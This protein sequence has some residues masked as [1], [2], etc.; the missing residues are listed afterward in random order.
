MTI[1]YP[2]FQR[3]RRWGNLCATWMGHSCVYFEYWMTGLRMLCD[4]VFEDTCV[5]RGV[6]EHRLTPPPCKIE[7]I[8]FIDVVLISNSHPEHLSYRTIKKIHQ[9]HPFCQ[10]IVPKGCGDWF[11]ENGISKVTELDWCEKASF[12]ALPYASETDITSNWGKDNFTRRTIK[13]SIRCLPCQYSRPTGPGSRVKGL[14][15]SWLIE[16][17]GFHVFFCGYASCVPIGKDKKY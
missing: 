16:S 2:N 8:P 12:Q 1:D 9:I 4:P 5:Y 17:Q 10:Y 7:D 6:K 14:W 3:S 11:R 15:A 13:A